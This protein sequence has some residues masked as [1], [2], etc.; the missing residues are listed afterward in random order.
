MNATKPVQIVG[1]TPLSVILAERV[2][3]RSNSVEQHASVALFEQTSV[4]II[5]DQWQ[6]VSLL[7]LIN[8]LRR[9]RTL[10][11]TDSK[12]FGIR[13]ENITMNEHVVYLFIKSATRAVQ[14]Y[15]LKLLQ[16]R[17]V[18]F[19]TLENRADPQQRPSA[20]LL[21]RLK[22]NDEVDA[23]FEKRWRSYFRSST[24][25]VP[26]DSFI[27]SRC[28][29]NAD[30]E[31]SPR[32]NAFHAIFH[33]L[34]QCPTVKLLGSDLFAFELAHLMSSFGHGR[35]HLYRMNPEETSILPVT[36]TDKNLATLFEVFAKSTL[37]V[38]EDFHRFKMNSQGELECETFTVPPMPIA[39]TA[40]QTKKSQ[41]TYLKDFR[42]QSLTQLSSSNI[43]L[44]MK[45]HSHASLL[46]RLPT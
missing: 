22:P 16:Q 1:F 27:M 9:C 8:L 40:N 7:C 5:D 19:V 43:R 18:E 6:S 14:M 24:P 46:H 10:L 11:S 13:V 34:L 45:N 44:G 35:V 33:E 29:A 32:L 37:N 42:Q 20:G 38:I 25:T 36:E 28:R 15:Y 4:S 3:Y 2:T 21:E 17:H 23:A 39:R 26:I 31:P 30:F 41:R 12:K